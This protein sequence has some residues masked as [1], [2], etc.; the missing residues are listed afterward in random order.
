MI[1]ALRRAGCLLC[2]CAALLALTG[3]GG[4]RGPT[5]DD[6]IVVGRNPDGTPQTV[7]TGRDPNAA[8]IQAIA[9]KDQGNCPGA[10]ILLQP[11][12]GLGPGYETAQT[13]LGACLLAQDDTRDEGVTWLTRAADAG[14]P[15]AQFALAQ[16]YG[17]ATPARDGTTA[18]YWLALFDNNPAQAR[19]GFRAPDP[20]VLRTLRA[21]LSTTE[22]DAGAALAS[23]WERKLWIP[24]TPPD[25]QG[26]RPEGRGGP[27]PPRPH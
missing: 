4:R 27:A 16:H 8:Y 18:A 13:A 22:K 24:P 1:R 14:W 12:A 6:R 17:A 20:N 5:P 15:E 7:R 3:C 23:G 26:P 19:V 21:S 25:D 10:I 2:A 9:L 11:V